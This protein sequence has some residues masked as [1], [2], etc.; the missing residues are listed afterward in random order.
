MRCWHI[1]GY[2]GLTK[3]YDRKLSI[4][5]FSEA[6]LKSLL[7]ALTAKAGLNMDEVVGAYVRKN[8]K[9]HNN[10]LVVKRGFR[11]EFSCGE[12]PYFI[13]RAVDDNG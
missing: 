1:E 5:Y 3:I 4:G 11:A 6:Q 12:N 8:S 10:L 2:E 13:A 7:M 9:I